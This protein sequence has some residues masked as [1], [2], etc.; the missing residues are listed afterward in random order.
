MAIQIVH[1][2]IKLDNIFVTS[3]GQ[4]KVLKLRPGET[5]AGNVD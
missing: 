5:G 4:A 3:R 1:R 2:D